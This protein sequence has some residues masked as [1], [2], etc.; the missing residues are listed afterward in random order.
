M[1]VG[2]AGRQAGLRAGRLVG[3]H[4]GG[5]GGD[6][7][8]ARR[9]TLL[10]VPGALPRLEQPLHEAVPGAADTH[11]VAIAHGCHTLLEVLAMI[12]LPKAQLRIHEVD[13][14]CGAVDGGHDLLREQALRDTHRVY[15]LPLHRILLDELERLVEIAHL[16]VH[17]R[18]R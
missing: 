7:A 14:F 2:P 9:E 16:P 15:Q 1:L 8:A 5:V 12:V 11:G 17:I 4:G 18:L 3:Q 13:V 10:R 6:A